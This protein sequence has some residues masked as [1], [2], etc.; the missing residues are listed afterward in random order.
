MDNVEEVNNYIEMFAPVLLLFPVPPYVQHIVHLM[1][2][3]TV[4]KEN[5]LLGP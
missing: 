3:E 4:K 2:S 1:A 5:K